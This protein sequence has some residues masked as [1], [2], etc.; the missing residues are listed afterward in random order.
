M[1]VCA[2]EPSCLKSRGNGVLLGGMSCDTVGPC[3]NNEK[4]T[5]FST[6]GGPSI[7]YETQ[8]FSNTFPPN[9]AKTTQHFSN[10]FN[11]LEK[12]A[13]RRRS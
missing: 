4:T 12:N 11:D 3:G 9:E 7:S 6:A 2:E 10:A 8:H 1:Q 5:A 13:Q